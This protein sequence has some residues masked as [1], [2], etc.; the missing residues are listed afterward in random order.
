MRHCSH[1]R[2]IVSRGSIQEAHAIM[3]RDNIGGQLRNWQA[4]DACGKSANMHVWVRYGARW[5]ACIRAG[6]D[7]LG[8]GIGKRGRTAFK[9][10]RSETIRARIRS[11]EIR[12]SE[13]GKLLG[14]KPKG[15]GSAELW[16]G[17][18]RRPV[19]ARW[20]IDSLRA[21]NIR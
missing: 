16:C 15:S 10:E 18:C 21:A 9:I 13:C 19:D 2:T 1:I 11:D 8:G 5:Q 7:G 12:C 20:N 17:R 14:R 3:P 6:I 4:A